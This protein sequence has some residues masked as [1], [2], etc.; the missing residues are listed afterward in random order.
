[1]PGLRKRSRSPGKRSCTRSR[2]RGDSKCRIRK[3]L[4]GA[5]GL[6]KPKACRRSKSRSKSSRRRRKSSKS[7]SRSP[8]RHYRKASK[9]PR[10]R[11]SKSRSR[12]RSRKARKSRSRSRSRSFAAA[13]SHSASYKK[14]SRSKS[15]SKSRKRR[16]KSRS[17]SRSRSQSHGLRALRRSSKG[18]RVCPS[19]CTPRGKGRRCRYPSKGPKSKRGGFCKYKLVKRSRSPAKRKSYSSAYSYCGMPAT[20]P[21]PAAVTS[22]YQAY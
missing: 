15:R 22:Y 16:T 3:G 12:S 21:V 1:M 10:R 2:S 17:S 20:S 4:L 8:K 14:K 9:S 18:H 6:C 7:R 11:K 5:G 19:P 13:F